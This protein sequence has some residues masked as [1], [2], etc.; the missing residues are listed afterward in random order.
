MTKRFWALTT[1]LGVATVLG[2][3]GT[4]K[5]SRNIARNPTTF[6]E[7]DAPKPVQVGQQYRIGPFDELKVVIFQVP[8]LSTN[9]TVDGAGQ[10]SLPLIGEVPVAG[11]TPAQVKAQLEKLY[12]AKYLQNPQIAVTVEKAVSQRVTVDGAVAQPGLYAITGNT[13]LLQ[14]VS[15]AHGARDD[16][17]LSR[18]VIFRQINGQR[19]AA[20]YDLR[21]VRRGVIDDPVIYGDDVV[22]VDGSNVRKNLH[23]LIG[24]LPL[25][26][27]FRPF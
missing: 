1:C 4:G 25:L 26:T 16:A 13:T 9:P 12:G 20:A 27:I 23:E 8:D 11:R 17:L 15:L 14:A 7:P 22:V 24:S 21:Q 18:V 6:A 19:Q 2:G 5:L 10:V 3:C